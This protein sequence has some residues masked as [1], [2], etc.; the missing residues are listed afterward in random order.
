MSSR[1]LLNVGMIFA[2]AVAAIVLQT[3]KPRDAA[4]AQYALVPVP[5]AEIRAIAIERV[6]SPAITLQREASQWRMTAPVKARLDDTALARVLDL[7]RLGAPNKL[8]AVDLGR[9]G[10]DQPWA[11]LRFGSHALEFGSTNTVTEELYVRSGDAVY[12]IP[13]RHARAIPATAAS[14]IAHRM[15]AADETLAA[16]ELPAFSLRHD[17]TRWQM[18]PPDPGL[19]QDD[20][21]RWTEQ[22]RYASSITT[23]PGEPV[24]RAD[25]VVELRDGR[26]IE[27]GIKA[28][29]PELVLHRRDEGLDYHFNPR[30]AALLLSS[31]SAAANQKP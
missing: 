12:A 18:N 17:G 7:S 22:W 9:Y 2:A 3:Y 29:T 4:P 14:L 26:R 27:F 11:R 16:V 28:R 6:N 23:R 21:V 15:F 10:L 5:Q 24:G 13:A 20:L 25:A 8:A 19:S 1:A 31:P 30:M